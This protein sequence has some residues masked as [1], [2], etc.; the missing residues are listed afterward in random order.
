[1]DV[2]LVN[3]GWSGGPYGVGERMKIGYTRAM[4][5]AAL[6]GDLA[7]V[8]MET[9]PTFGVN[10]PTQCPEVPEEVLK[11]RN[12]WSDKAA[13]DEQARKLARMFGEN[14]EAFAEEVS[15]EVRK[16]GPRME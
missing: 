10:V 1:M 4:V 7:D 11:P 14:F 3:T 8:P 6:A 13:Y 2:W 16:T 5:R 15:E 12:T 9:D